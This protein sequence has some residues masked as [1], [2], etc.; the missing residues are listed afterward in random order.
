MGAFRDFFMGDADEDGGVYR[1]LPWLEGAGGSV[2]WCTRL[3]CLGRRVLAMFM[4]WVRGSRVRCSSWLR[5]V[6]AAGEMQGER[7]LIRPHHRGRR[8]TKCSKFWMGRA[9]LL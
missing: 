9:L 1:S 5:L 8:E 3:V 2:V 6:N 4:F 7:A